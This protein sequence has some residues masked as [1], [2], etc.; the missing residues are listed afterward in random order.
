MANGPG[1]A[2][3][4]GARYTVGVSLPFTGRIPHAARSLGL[5]VVLA[6]GALL[7]SGPVA[8]AGPED[9]PPPSST[10][11]DVPRL[12]RPEASPDDV[13]VTGD[14]VT[15]RGRILAELQSGFLFR[16]GSGTTT[17]VPFTDIVDLTR[18]GMARVV[19]SASPSPPPASPPVTTMVYRS[20]AELVEELQGSPSYTG[21]TRSEGVASLLELLLPGV[22]L[23]YAGAWVEGIT[24]LVVVVS[25]PA[26]LS[27]SLAVAAGL[28]YALGPEDRIAQVGLAM[29]V[30]LGIILAAAVV[31]SRVAS[32]MRAGPAAAAHNQRV[33]SDLVRQAR[34]RPVPVTV[35]PVPAPEAP[36]VIDDDEG[37]PLVP[38]HPL[39]IPD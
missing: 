24:H 18:P 25:I 9:A 30:N 32:V 4:R 38:G 22:G 5:G 36:P 27:L 2:G 20:R 23:M 7:A 37:L 8:A 35:T 10:T 3:G 29:V 21:S 28:M 31:S 39:G 14:G 26:L 1:V 12:A 13:I 11:Q 17:V 15:H 16:E 19:A 6:L 34:E 33:M